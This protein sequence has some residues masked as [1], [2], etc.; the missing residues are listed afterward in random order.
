MKQHLIIIRGSSGI[1][2]S[3]ISKEV[4]KKIPGLVSLIDSD[5]LRFDFIPKR[6]KSFDDRELIY[7]NLWDLTKNS[8]NQGLNVIFEGILAKK[9][10]NKLNIDK[11]DIYKK[12]GVKVSKIHLTC[13]EKIQIKRI[14]N[15]PDKN[16]I[17]QL[18][19]W[20]ELCT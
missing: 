9:T 2:K 18:K 6:T 19:E 20:N 17:K 14:K 5:V 8:L 11:Y 13:S 16:S 7:K 1:G 12:K 4:A 15:R 10:N 3:T